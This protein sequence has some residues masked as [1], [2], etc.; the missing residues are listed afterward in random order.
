[1]L[2]NLGPTIDRGPEPNH[3]HLASGARLSFGI[4]VKPDCSKGRLVSYRFD[5][6]HDG[7]TK[8]PLIRFELRDSPHHDPLQ[9]PLAHFH[10]GVENLRLPTGLV[11]P[12]EVLDL[13]FFVVE[14]KIQN[15]STTAPSGT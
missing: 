10:P 7:A 14:P 13:L 9:E 11:D 6:R 5:Y 12:L 1:M 8:L 3:F 2:I 15:G 4:T